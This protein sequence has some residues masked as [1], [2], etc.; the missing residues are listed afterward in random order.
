MLYKLC[1][2]EFGTGMIELDADRHEIERTVQEHP[3]RFQRYSDGR[4]TGSI[5]VYAIEYGTADQYG[6]EKA[7]A[8]LYPHPEHGLIWLDIG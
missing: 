7:T 3:E 8:A 5:F 2:H 6:R 1:P 4:L